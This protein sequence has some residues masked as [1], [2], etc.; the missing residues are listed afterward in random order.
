MSELSM[1]EY[2]S[3]DVDYIDLDA[4]DYQQQLEGQQQME[5]ADSQ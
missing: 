4:L 2:E 3:D 5:K 1:S